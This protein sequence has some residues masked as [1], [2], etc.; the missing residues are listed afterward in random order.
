MSVHMTLI[1]QSAASSC[2]KKLVPQKKHAEALEWE[3]TRVCVGGAGVEWWQN[4]V[5]YWDHSSFGKKSKKMSKFH[6]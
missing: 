3:V 5:L 4:P 1:A 6:F 2:C